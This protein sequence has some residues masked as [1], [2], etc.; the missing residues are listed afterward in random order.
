MTT[1]LRRR[2]RDNYPSKGQASRRST[3]TIQQASL[4]DHT[5][6]SGAGS[7]VLQN[8]PFPSGETIRYV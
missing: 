6:G 4:R 5:Q 3:I 2:P 1:Y 8:S 7:I